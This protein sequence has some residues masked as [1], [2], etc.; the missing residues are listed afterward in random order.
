MTSNKQLF[1]D[2]LAI[3]SIKLLDI[4]YCATMYFML[5]LVAVYMFNVFSGQYDPEQ[6]NDK[7]TMRLIWEV[8]TRIWIIGVLAYAARNLIAVIPWPLEGVLGYE[9]LRIPEVANTNIFVAFIAVF[10]SQLQAKT[11]AIKARLGF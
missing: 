11:K 6:E 3:R 8:I 1:R 2:D 4:G 9:H 5:A 10:D 7:S